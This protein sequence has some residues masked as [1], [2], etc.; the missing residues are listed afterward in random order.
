MEREERRRAL[1][2]PDYDPHANHGLFD[3]LS[4]P[5]EENSRSEDMSMHHNNYSYMEGGSSPTSPDAVSPP[6][7]VFDLEGDTSDTSPDNDVAMLKLKLKE[8]SDKGCLQR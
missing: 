3:P 7:E 5:S 6:A 1:G 8:V 4:S 2:G